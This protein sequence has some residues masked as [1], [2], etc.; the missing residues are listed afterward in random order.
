VPVERSW[1]SEVG[2]GRA[3]TCL[4]VEDAALIGMAM[5]SYL[6]DQGFE[7]ATVG[8]AHQ[9]AAWLDRHAPSVAIVDYQ[10]ADGPCTEL[11][12][13]LRARGVPFLIYSGSRRQT[14][15]ELRDAIWISKP[16]SRA[17][18][19]DAVESLVEGTTPRQAA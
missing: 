12:P 5:E 1:T 7:C 16:A 18:L 15:G 10:L 14:S 11:L 6:E 13:M 19:L 17:T 2:E 4:I 9:G 8:S 3:R